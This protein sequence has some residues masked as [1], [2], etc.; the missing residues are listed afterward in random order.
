MCKTHQTQ[1]FQPPRLSC[2]SFGDICRPFQPSHVKNHEFHFFTKQPTKPSSYTVVH[3][4]KWP[5]AKSTEL[6]TFAHQEFYDIHLGTFVNHFNL[7]ISKTRNFNFSQNNP[8]SNLAMPRCTDQLGHVQSPPN[9][10]LS[11]IK[12]FMVFICELL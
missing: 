8:P 2:Y 4:P 6:K 10:K 9:S 3:R 5:C 7:H 12:T 11:C 1:N